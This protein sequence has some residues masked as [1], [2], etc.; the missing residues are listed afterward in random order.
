[1]FRSIPQH[2]VFVAFVTVAWIGY[3]PIPARAADPSSE[4][5][6]F[7]RRVEDETTNEP[8]DGAT[9]V[10][11]RF[12]RSGDEWKQLE[13]TTH[14]TDKD[15]KFTFTFKKEHTADPSLF[16]SFEVSHSDYCVPFPDSSSYA[17]LADGGEHNYALR[18]IRLS[19]GEEIFGV[20]QSPDGK[21]AAGARVTGF[22]AL[23]VEHCL[24]E[25]K[26]DSQGRFRFNALA[27]GDAFVIARTESSAPTTFPLGKKRDN[28]GRLRLV[29]GETLAGRV[30]DTDGAPI[31]NVWV[32]ANTHPA[33][34]PDDPLSLPLIFRSA[35]TDAD[36]RFQFAP[37]SAGKHQLSVSPSP[38]ESLLRD[39]PGAVPSIGKQLPAVF[40]PASQLVTITKGK[41]PAPITLE[42]VPHVAVTA[43]CIDSA[44]KASPMVAFHLVMIDDKKGNNFVAQGEADQH[45]ILKLLAPLSAD[46]GAITVFPGPQQVAAWRH[47][48]DEDWSYSEVIGLRTLDRDIDLEIKTL[49]C[50]VL[51]VRTEEENGKSMRDRLAIKYRVDPAKPLPKGL[52]ND[53]DSDVVIPPIREGEWRTQRL[54]PDFAFTVTATASGYKPTSQEL[55]LSEGERQEVVL[56]LTKNQ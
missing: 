5:L 19:P 51:T 3:F 20:V 55:K 14:R 16:A 46:D 13:T 56:R 31:P 10:V 35:K 21:G 8:V 47:S 38:K 53:L 52:S 4:S 24:V 34:G 40:H 9:V 33:F 17:S 1:M 23:H 50:P 41:K 32:I 12:V 27:G 29:T 42:A 26:A 6:S 54:V 28:V 30:L 15:G 49:V 36:G 37:L 25:T 43:K 18:S 48:P 22:S 44:G 39:L 45:G 2:R 7:T 11:R